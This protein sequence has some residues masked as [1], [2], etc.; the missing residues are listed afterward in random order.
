MGSGSNTAPDDSQ[1]R[2]NILK[3][4]LVYITGS[5]LLII[6]I[7]LLS[8]Y[9]SYDIGIPSNY[10]EYLKTKAT[11]SLF[12]LMHLT[13][14]F[15]GYISILLLYAVASN[16]FRYYWIW[17]FEISIPSAI[18]HF[19]KSLII[20]RI[21]GL[22]IIKEQA[23]KFNFVLILIVIYQQ[24]C[25]HKFYNARFLIF[26]C[27]SIIMDIIG[28]NTSSIINKLKDD[29]LDISNLEPK[30]KEILEDFF[31]KTKFDRVL[32]LITKNLKTD[33]LIPLFDIYTF[34]LC[35]VIHLPEK[36]AKDSL[37]DMFKFVL[38]QNYGLGCFKSGIAVQVLTLLKDI[39][40]LAALF[41]LAY[42]NYKDK[43]R[44][45]SS[46]KNIDAHFQYTIW[47][48]F[49]S[50]I[51]YFLLNCYQIYYSLRADDIAISLC[52]HLDGLNEAFKQK[53]VDFERTCTDFLIN[54]P[55]YFPSNN[56]PS[57][58]HRYKRQYNKIYRSDIFK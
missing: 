40:I 8:Y 9:I 21:P 53:S 58:F 35:D 52:G 10:P 28:F 54:Q 4:R 55:P 42:G 39:I 34:K 19:L 44:S 30:I 1:L 25:L 22:N 7:S 20:L 26:P 46:I 31:L 47:I 36:I 56:T 50:I 49:G 3:K 41:K 17:I 15:F 51:F 23:F 27:F 14:D 37:A 12:P 43:E 45:T 32:V 11:R 6:Y 24:A 18:F 16:F 2:I 5:I 48:S 38:Y 13:F 29:S 33:G 57:L